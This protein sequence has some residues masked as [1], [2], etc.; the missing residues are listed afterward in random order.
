MSWCFRLRLELGAT[1]K[2][3][4]EDIEWIIRDT[5]AGKI[6]LRPADDQR[7][8]AQARSLALSEVGLQ[9]TPRLRRLVP[10]GV[11]G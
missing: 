7:S 1:A 9:P 6:H 8:L 10:S 3:R 5:D 11:I 4:C 2:L